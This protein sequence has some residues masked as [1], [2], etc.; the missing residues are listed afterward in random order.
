M[1]LSCCSVLQR[2]EKGGWEFLLY[3]SKKVKLFL[4]S[5]LPSP[6]YGGHSGLC[7][8][9]GSIPDLR[10]GAPGLYRRPNVQ[11]RLQWRPCGLQVRGRVAEVVVLGPHWLNVPLPWRP[12]RGGRLFSD[13]AGT[14]LLLLVAFHQ[15]G[16]RVRVGVL[17]L[18]RIFLCDNIYRNTCKTKC[19][20]SVKTSVAG[21]GSET[22]SVGIECF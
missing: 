11:P 7:R 6:R 13:S 21:T 9:Q 3:K 19:T 22:G 1:Y 10:R 17:L 20:E 16:V 18:C 4:H 12:V 15:C 5:C 8:V 14:L 2:F